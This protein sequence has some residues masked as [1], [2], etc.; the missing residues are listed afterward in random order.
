[1]RKNFLNFD[2]NFYGFGFE[3]AKIHQEIY[4]Q[5]ESENSQRSFGF[6][7]TREINSR[8]LSK[9]FNKEEVKIS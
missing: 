3:I 8:A 1:M 5:R 2:F 7:R 4:S 9:I 6:E